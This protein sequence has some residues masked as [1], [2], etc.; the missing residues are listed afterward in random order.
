MGEWSVNP[1]IPGGVTLSNKK[2]QPEL[3]KLVFREAAATTRGRSSA[4]EAGSRACL[5]A[6]FPKPQHMRFAPS[7][8]TE[9]SGPGVGSDGASLDAGTRL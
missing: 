1:G 5:F 2:A 3:G 4:S 6:P 7:A 9:L 8:G